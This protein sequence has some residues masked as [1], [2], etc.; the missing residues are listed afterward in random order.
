MQVRAT[1]TTVG[2]FDINVILCPCFRLILL[3]HHLP[4]RG[5]LIQTRPSLEFVR[6]A[7]FRLLCIAYCVQRVFQVIRE[8]ESILVL[9]ARGNTS[10]G[11]DIFI[12]YKREPFLATM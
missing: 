9:D 12:Y 6:C 1:N 4:V 8:R 10:L 7:H 5:L 11:Y 2:D 3:P